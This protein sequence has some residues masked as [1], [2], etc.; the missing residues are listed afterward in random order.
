MV[1]MCLIFGSTL[2]G[3]IYGRHSGPFLVILDRNTRSYVAFRH[4]SGAGNRPERAEISPCSRKN[5]RPNIPLSRRVLPADDYYLIGEFRR[6]PSNA[7]RKRG[8]RNFLNDDVYGS[9]T[10]IVRVQV[11]GNK[12]KGAKKSRSVV[13]VCVFKPWNLPRPVSNE[14]N[15]VK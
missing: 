1:R 7:Y 10:R 11:F 6:T 9:S 14:R 2:A 15:N 8:N 4:F 12:R 3:S 13:V 5:R